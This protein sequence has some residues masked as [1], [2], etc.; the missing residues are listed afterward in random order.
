MSDI[1]VTILGLGRIG[2]SMGLALKRYNRSGSQHHFNITGY[3]SR[4]G[5]VKTAQ[6]M[7]AVD[8]IETK[9]FVAVR[10]RDII[11][12]ALP[13]S[14]V[15]E[16]YELIAPD[17]REGAVILDTSVL[18]E[19]SLEWAKKQLPPTAHLV[20]VAPIIGP[21]YLFDG[22]DDAERAVE[23]YF[24]NGTMLL[25]PSVSCVPEAVEL[26]TNFSTLLG[27][28][29]HF[30][31]PLEFDGLSAATDGLPSLIGVVFF[32]TL[33]K[34]QGWNDVQ[35]VTNPAFGMLTHWLFDTHPDDLRDS[36]VNNRDNLLRYT[37]EFLDML[38][39]FRD[40]LAREN[41]DALEAALISS[42]E[43]YEAWINR[44]Y[45]ANWDDTYK[46]DVASATGTIVS[47]LIGGKMARKLMGGDKDQDRDR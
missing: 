11:V 9:A 30:L 27:A 10:D 8:S 41:R 19:P 12:V 31:D 4:P 39:R 28:T 13:Y 40:I 24:D 37:D 5:M 43:E 7:D 18:K 1:S 38:G 20:G 16:A 25:M 33:L 14:E 29:P 36:W 46:P 35:R 42:S 15:K 22:V 2:T 34:S 45:K 3:D 21:R 32:H 6:K 47:G 26:A 17:L 44:R 23:D